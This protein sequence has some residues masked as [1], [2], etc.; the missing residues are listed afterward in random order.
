MNNRK[1]RNLTP[2]KKDSISLRCLIYVTFLS[3]VSPGLAA[4]QTMA[5]QLGWLPSKLGICKGEYSILYRLIQE[6]L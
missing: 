2:Q 4:E 3:F 5:Q 1:K 6:F